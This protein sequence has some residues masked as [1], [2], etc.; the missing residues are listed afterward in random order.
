MY[1]VYNGFETRGVHV[2]AGINRAGIKHY[3]NCCLPIL[4]ICQSFC[5]YD[6]SFNNCSG[7]RQSQQSC[8]CSSGVSSLV[9][10]YGCRSSI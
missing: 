10:C 8:D 6:Q 1:K 7:G 4:K 5:P 3:N 9:D 2:D